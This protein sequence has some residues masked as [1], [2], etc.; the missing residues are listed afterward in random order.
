M[1]ESIRKANK[2]IARNTFFLY[3]RKIITLIIALYTSRVLLQT[4]GIDDFGLYGLIGSIVVLFNSL[5]GL[6]ASSIQRF[7][8]IEKNNS[9]ECQNRIFSMGVSIHIGIAI[10]F[11]VVVEIAGLIMI[12]NLNLHPEK[13]SVAYIVLQFSNLA[14]VVSIL[15]VPYDALMMAKERF[16]AIAGFSLLDSIMR[17]VI[18]YLLVLSPA[19]HLIFYSILVFCV[20]LLMRLLNAMYCKYKFPLIARYRFVREGSLFKEMTKFAGW[21]FFGNLGYSLT[22]QGLNFVLN[23]FGGVIANAARTIAYQVNNNMRSFVVDIAVAFTPQSMMAYKDN[24]TRFYN[25]QFFSS[26]ASSVVFLIFAFPIYL[27]TAPILKLWLG[28]CPEYSVAFIHGI[29]FYSMV[30]NWHGPVDIAFKSANRMQAYQICEIVIMVL[31]LPI[32]W[33]CLHLGAPLYSLFVVMT[34]VEIVNL[35]SILQ[36]A[37]MQIGFPV[38]KFMKDV[39][40]PTCIVIGVFVIGYFI[41]LFQDINTTSIASL[42]LWCAVL[43]I[44][45]M[46]VNLLIVF[47]S[48]ERKKIFEIIKVKQGL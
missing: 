12:P 38:W 2:R 19:N 47:N 25:L 17:L 32:S 10:L 37:K 45:A 43:A 31:N 7:L 18:I 46:I 35:I 27:L 6:F 41:F 4:L 23:I 33:L 42:L 16:D 13:I 34:I 3:I 9:D 44:I 48:N 21:N 28:E 1:V 26:K 8:N 39:V 24:K 11:F 22:N 30:R 40:I 15:T 14:S 20:S 5:R 36:I 29:F